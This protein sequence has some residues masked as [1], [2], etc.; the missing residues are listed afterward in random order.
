MQGGLILQL[1]VQD[2]L[3]R[4]HRSVEPLEV[5]QG[6]G[7]EDPDDADLVVG[8][9]QGSPELVAMDKS[10]CLIFPCPGLRRAMHH[11]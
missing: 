11:G 5:Q 7:W 10:Q 8:R 9:W 4:L 6:L 2:T 1:A 3:D